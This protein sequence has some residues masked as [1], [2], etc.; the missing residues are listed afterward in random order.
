MQKPMR[1]ECPLC[2]LD[3]HNHSFKKISVRENIHIYYTCPSEAKLYN[4]KEGILKHY[5]GM[6]NELPKDNEWIWIFDSFD[7]G[8]KHCLEIDVGIGLAKL[9]TKK[10]S[11]NLKKIIIINPSFYISVTYKTLSLFLSNSVK[12]IIEFNYEYKSSKEVLNNLFSLKNDKK[13]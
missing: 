11:K 6:L 2:R 7:F 9:I 1:Y 4:D 5:N 10:F 13:R 8:L 12:N 3:E